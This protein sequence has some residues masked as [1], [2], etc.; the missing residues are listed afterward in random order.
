MKYYL[1]RH[2]SGYVGNCLLWWRKGGCGCT[3]NLDDAQVFDGDDSYFRS[4]A[5]DKAKYTAWEKDYIDALAQ[6]HV[7]H[8]YLN[9]DLKGVRND[10]PRDKAAI[11]AAGGGQ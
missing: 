6:R 8:Q 11:H 1:Q 3:C 7:D 4:A 2:A 9:F 10:A 5:G